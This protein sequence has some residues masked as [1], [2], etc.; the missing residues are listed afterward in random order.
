MSQLTIIQNVSNI[1]GVFAPTFIKGNSDP[2]AL[3]MHALLDRG[4]KNLAR[5][6]SSN[7]SGWLFLQ[8]T[9]LITTIADQSTYTVPDEFVSLIRDTVWDRDEY[10]RLNSLYSPKEWA[11]IVFGL[12]V[13]PQIAPAIR[14]IEESGIRKFELFPTPGE[15]D[16]NFA[17]YYMSNHWVKYADGD[18]VGTRA[19][20]ENDDDE[21]FFD[22][23]LLEMDL[24]WRFKQSRGLSFAVELAEFEVERDSRFASDYSHP[25][26]S[27]SRREGR[28]NNFNIDDQPSIRIRATASGDIA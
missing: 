8:K 17:Y 7:D 14:M 3:A 25:V 18:D 13:Y 22:E 23:D 9:G 16:R 20:Y 10:W 15:S 1:I 28:S 19:G 12:E 5:M 11:T 26:I 24:N 4:G 21:S 2:I 27:L 6:R